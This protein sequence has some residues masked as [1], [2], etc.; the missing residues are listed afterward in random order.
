MRL[1]LHGTGRM[2][3]AVEK[4]AIERQ[5]EVVGRFNRTTP[6]S[7]A[8][9]NDVDAVVDFSNLSSL[10]LLVDSAC[11][12]G[13]NLVIGT[14]GWNERLD[15]IRRRC[16]AARIGV[17]HASNFSPGANILFALAQE[18]SR[19]FAAVGGYAAGIEERHHSKKADVPSGTAIT[20]R[21]KVREAAES[22]D[23]PIAASRV[24]A[25]FGRHTLFFDSPDD[26][27]EISHQARGRDGFARGAIL[28]AEL[29]DGKKG[30]FSFGDL[31]AL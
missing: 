17:V 27:V 16:E 2:G 6:L 24:G 25:E 14:T 19:R 30:F 9:L 23:P 31:I 1:A 8:A 3:V 7:A 22:F 26:V 20:I 10:D 21:N 28:A 5:H 29:L 18:A 13:V 12:A 15:E 11:A 4:I